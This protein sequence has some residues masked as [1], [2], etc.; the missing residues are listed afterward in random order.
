MH[1]D[2]DRYEND[3][4]KQRA[5]PFGHLA[6]RPADAY[7]VGCY[8]PGGD[9]CEKSSDPPTMDIGQYLGALRLFHKGDHGDHNQNCFDPLAQ[10]NG[11]RPEKGRDF[12]GRL[13]S[14]RFLGSC[15][16]T[17]DASP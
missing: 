6:A 2:P 12:A 1:P 17:I 10:E 5:D 8:D 7:E 4:R 15:Q 16:Q 14:Q 11:E 9:T 13:R 3:S